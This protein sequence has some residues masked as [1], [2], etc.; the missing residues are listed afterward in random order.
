[1]AQKLTASM[2]DRLDL[3]QKYTLRFCALDPTTGDPVSGVNVS[4]AQIHVS[5]VSSED[6]AQA[7]AVGPF[8]L[9]PLDELN[10][11]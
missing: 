10:S 3:D 7:L 5:L 4:L 9:I 11:G 2:P 6:G 1:M 8:Q